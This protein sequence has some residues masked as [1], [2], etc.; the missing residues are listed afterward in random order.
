MQHLIFLKKIK[1]IESSTDSIKGTVDGNARMLEPRI[2]QNSSSSARRFLQRPDVQK[3]IFI[4]IKESLFV[5]KQ[6]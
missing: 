2:K 5:T 6:Q 3:I 4:K 1:Y